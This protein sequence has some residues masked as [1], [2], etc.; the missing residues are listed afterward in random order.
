MGWSTDLL[1]ASFRGVQFECTSTDD[2]VSKA[3]SIKQ[4]PYSNDASIEDMGNNPRDI[5]INALYSGEG[6]KTWLDALEAALLATGSGELIHPVYGIQQVHVV[7]YNV[8]HNADNFDSC[9]I[10]MKFILA[11]DKKRELFVP[12]V[13]QQK[14]AI[15]S[16]VDVPA[17]S[18][19]K[20]LKQL[21]LINPN[22]YFNVV[23][24]L[25]NGINKFRAGMNI[26]KTTVDNL[27]SP[28]SV[29]VG[30][31]DD[32]TKL[33]TF[34]ANISAISKWRDLIHRVKRFE[35]L[36]Q[37]DDSPAEVKQLWRATQVATIVAVTQE[38][39][40]KVRQEMA[41]DKIISLTPI[42]LALIRQQNRQT[43]Q[44]AIAEER[45][46][47]SI[48]SVSQI[49][50]YKSIADQV[51]VAEAVNRDGYGLQISGRDLVG[52]LI[53]CSVP[54]FNGR[55][56]TLE[57]LLNKYVRGGDFGSLFKEVKIQNNA[58][59]KNKI[60]VEPS[61]SVWDSIAKAAAVTGQHVW[62]EPDG[63]LVIGDPF[64]NPYQ[65]QTPLRL[66][67]PLENSNN[68]LDLQY[69]NDVSSVFSEIKVLSQDANAQHILAESKAKTQYSF[70]RLKIVTLGDVETKA[71]AEAAL[72]KI[73]KDND[74]EAYSL[75]ATVNGWEIDQK[76]W[77]PAWYVNVETNAISNATAKWAVYG[78]TLLLSRDLGKTTK[79]RLKR[80]G[81]WAQPLVHKEKRR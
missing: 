22:K 24:N 11:K 50:I 34:D 51:Q 20:L 76:V 36:F 59:L 4:A 37:N 5:S 38:I 52:Q 42:D 61:E 70:N 12:V 74:L 6:Y 3:L 13:V 9:T 35:K 73:K 23:N 30:L 64:A 80:Q 29:I 27:L 26:V 14:I 69:D 28:A 58:W 1:D 65:V 72:A 67:K 21:E 44:Q 43:L 60:S 7:N 68:I 66:I 56:I 39:V 2:S 79:L 77:T 81:D 62:L 75:S 57:E 25:R 10:A 54:I 18:L 53:D 17:S 15:P 78:R 33:V 41:E 19:E 45:L 31:V 63:T 40:S 16:I 32:V 55:Q 8:T 48:D 46:I 49:A 47:D 71:E